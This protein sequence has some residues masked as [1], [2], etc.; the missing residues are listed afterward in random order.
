AGAVEATPPAQAEGIVGLL[1]RWDIRPIKLRRARRDCRRQVQLPR[2]LG[3]ALRGCLCGGISA[4]SS[5]DEL[6]ETAGARCRSPGATGWLSGAAG[7]GAGSPGL[8]VRWHIRP[9]ELGRRRDCRA[10]TRIFSGHAPVP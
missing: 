5:W 1:A 3:L 8:L 6:E 9:V 2:G 4:Q 7:P 10:H